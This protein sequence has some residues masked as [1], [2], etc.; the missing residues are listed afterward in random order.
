VMVIA[1]LI[2]LLHLFF[3]NSTAFWPW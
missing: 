2:E 1:L 3:K